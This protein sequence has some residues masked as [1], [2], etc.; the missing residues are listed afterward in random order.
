MK[1]TAQKRANS[2]KTEAA[3][4][5]EKMIKDLPP[6][7]QQEVIDFAQHLAARRKKSRKRKLRMDWAGALKEYRDQFTSLE[8]Q[9][10]ALEWRIEHA[11]RRH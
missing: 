8:L 7:L 4:K 2:I 11:A 6:D 10:K 5:L 3:A 9:K 1:A